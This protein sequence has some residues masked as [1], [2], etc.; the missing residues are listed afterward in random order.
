MTFFQ[1]IKQLLEKRLGCAINRPADCEILANDIESITNDHVGVNTVKR[2]LGFK[3]DEREP[4]LTTLDIFARYLGCKD[5]EELKD[6]D[7]KSN[8]D[9]GDTPN[10]IKSE[11]I[12]ANGI[13]SFSYLPDR[14]VSIKKLHDDC[15]VVTE[16]QNGKLRINDVIS[17]SSFM[18]HYPLLIAEVIRNDKN[19]GTLL[20]G[21]VSG[22]TSITIS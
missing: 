11:N 8:S 7:S 10:F 17:V 9:F 22:L 1:Y 15:F 2:L 20:L 16:S 3:A 12:D 21:K 14:H 4:R 6:L 18:L 19:L 5:W 13:V